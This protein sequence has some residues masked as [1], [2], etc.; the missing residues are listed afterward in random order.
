MP[1]EVFTN[2][3]TFSTILSLQYFIMLASVHNSIAYM[4][5]AIPNDFLVTNNEI[6]DHKEF[7]QFLLPN[8][9]HEAPKSGLGSF[10]HII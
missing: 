10:N 9:L 4:I 8:S 2:E 7:A 6:H 1:C 3:E 5:S